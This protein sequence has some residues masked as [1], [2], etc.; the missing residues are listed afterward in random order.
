MP[1]RTRQS[2]DNS[3]L[4][5]ASVGSTPTAT[6]AAPEQEHVSAT[7]GYKAFLI[8][9]RDGQCTYVLQPIPRPFG[10]NRPPPGSTMGD[11]VESVI[12][13]LD[14]SFE[15]EPTMETFDG[16]EYRAEVH[17]DTSRFLF[18]AAHID[19]PTLRERLVP[20]RLSTILVTLGAPESLRGTAWW[21]RQWTHF[22]AD[23][24]SDASSLTLT[25]PC[26]PLVEVGDERVMVTL[27]M[28][29]PT[30][31]TVVEHG[32]EHGE[33]HSDGTD[34]D[35][36]DLERPWSS[37]DSSFG[38]GTGSDGSAVSEGDLDG[39]AAHSDSENIAAPQPE[40]T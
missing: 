38:V 36:A 19:V 5:S 39:A 33:E 16:T 37:D 13:R 17:P 15:N 24:P 40:S 1:P 3:Q 2:Q 35:Q 25:M 9:E 20:S 12:R 8:T 14:W 6:T 7:K 22:S 10:P 11:A 31:G 32:E 23:P 21:S 4:A 29:N 28:E 18:V 27:G 30:L 34:G 26:P